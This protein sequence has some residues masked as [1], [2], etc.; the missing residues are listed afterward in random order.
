MPLSSA[1]GP[2][3]RPNT[4]PPERQMAPEPRAC[5][6]GRGP[7][8]SQEPPRHRA[9]G[10]PWGVSWGQARAAPFVPLA[11]LSLPPASPPRECPPAGD[12]K[13]SA[14][15]LGGHLGD[16]SL[17]PKEVVRF[18]PG[19]CRW[20][21][22]SRPPPAPRRQLPLPPSPLLSRSEGRLLFAT[23]LHSAAFAVTVPSSR[24]RLPLTSPRGEV[25]TPERGS[26]PT[27]SRG[28]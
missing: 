8:A 4:G 15:R 21:L 25:S 2:H 12:V 11:A 17:K 16:P 26:H 10:P 28:F 13:A 1:A 22:R 18:P 5:V 24:N 9:R 20:G 3:H 6:D 23:C 14:K 27:R 19:T 7:R